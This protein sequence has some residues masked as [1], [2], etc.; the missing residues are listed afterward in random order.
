[1]EVNWG[2]ILALVRENG[3]GKST[4]IKVL[5]GVFKP[6]VGRLLLDGKEVVMQRQCG[7]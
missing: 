5:S 6:D 1:M 4:L 7:A 2:E 3:V